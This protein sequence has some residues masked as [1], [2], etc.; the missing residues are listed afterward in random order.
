[1]A[2]ESIVLDKR[3]K[4]GRVLGRGPSGIVHLAT[5]LSRGSECVVKRIYAKYANRSI[6][7]R[8]QAV[9][10]A[11]SDMM[12]PAVLGVLY[13]GYEPSGALYLC[14]RWCRAS[15]CGRASSVGRC[16]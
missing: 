4:V 11:A 14:R 5:D 15:R 1:M 13:T 2:T 10:H 6:L 9:S 12:H 8:V 3:F 16:R 7:D